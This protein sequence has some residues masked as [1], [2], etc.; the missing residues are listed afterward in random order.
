[1]SNEKRRQKKL[2]RKKQQRKQ[3]QTT[4][5][6]NK[7]R[8]LAEQ[9]ADASRYPLLHTRYQEIIFD[10]GIGHAM[11]SRQL[12]DGRIAV[13]MFLLDVFCL[14]VK[15]ALG[16]VVTPGIYRERFVDSEQGQQMV[17]APPEEVRKLVE[18]SV[19]FGSYCGL[20]PC[21][22]YRRVK[23]IFGDIDAGNCQRHFEF[24]REGVPDFIPGPYDSPQRIRQVRAELEER[25]GTDGYHFTMVTRSFDDSLLIE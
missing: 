1:M 14:G 23:P 15:D 16:F 22:D 10:V 6:K 18:D 3:R 11:I 9:M 19:A 21:A 13:A 20:Q 25:F 8:G 5:A 17:D 7:S 4:L 12:P 24:G 2:E